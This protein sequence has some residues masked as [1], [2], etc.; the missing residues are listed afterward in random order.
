MTIQEMK[1]RVAALWAAVSPG[2]ELLP[3][4]PAARA[5]KEVWEAALDAA[6]AAF[7][8]AWMEAD[9]AH[10]RARA[11]TAGRA[12]I[13]GT[14]AHVASAAQRAAAERRAR[15]ETATAHAVA[16]LGADARRA[17]ESDAEHRRAERAAPLRA[18]FVDC[19]IA[20]GR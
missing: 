3:P 18:S 8:A 16:I 20:G 14:C 12:V 1:A 2:I 9:A 4:A 5:Q 6:E 19:L 11:I 15:I 7:A 13:V 17:R 10:A